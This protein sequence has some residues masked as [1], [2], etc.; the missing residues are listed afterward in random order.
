MAML[1]VLSGDL[2]GRSYAVEEREFVIGRAPSC[3]LVI[4]KRYI[5]REHA[6]IQRQGREFVIGGLSRKNPILVGERPIRE[7]RLADGDVFEVCGIQFRFRLDRQPAASPRHTGARMSG[8]RSGRDA[9]AAD[10]SWVDDRGGGG[11]ADESW[12]DDRRGGGGADESWVDDRRGG[13]ADGW[14][15]ASDVGRP[16]SD[17]G[18]ARGGGRR[19]VSD[20]GPAR[21]GGGRFVSDEGPVGLSGEGDVDDSWQDAG[22]FDDEPAPAPAPAAGTRSSAARPGQ[23][24][25]D[26]EEDSGDR[27]SAS[28][29]EKTGAI[30]VKAS[31]GMSGSDVNE[32]TAELGVKAADP[33]DPDY[34]PFAEVDAAGPK[35]QKTVDPKREKLLR[36]I[37]VL[38][39]FL[40][41]VAGGIV[42]K[43]TRP[44][45]WRE[46]IHPEP[47]KLGIGQTRKFAV[48]WAAE[49]P[50]A[51][52]ARVSVIGKPHQWQARDPN[53]AYV[54][55]AVPDTKQRSI[56]LIE[57]VDVGETSFVLT[58][59]ERRER[60]SYEVL[61][62]GTDPHEELRLQR[63][64]EL[65]ALP[66]YELQ[67]RAE[68]HLASGD[69]F[70]ADRDIDGKESSIRMAVLEYAAA[71]DAA[72]VARD[73]LALEATV[74]QE[75]TN[76]VLKCEEKEQEAREAYE[77]FVAQR[78]ALYQEAVRKG[79]PRLEQIDRLKRV[80]RAINHACD[81]RYL[82]FELL[83]ELHFE[84]SYSGDGTEQCEARFH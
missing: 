8:S 53:T 6:R 62:E 77:Q 38:A 58:F 22:D 73:Q 5:S 19:P 32:Q 3:N 24:V 76:L 41:A 82:R 81:V 12:V 79:R 25:F 71:S 47:I 49:N 28:A 84:E 10:E 18:P 52:R 59:P 45:P 26:V 56:F 33:D 80:L 34:D 72:T 15:P 68:S 63:R 64:K 46:A 69:K 51:G 2:A 7:H 37:T 42:W 23:V 30:D 13:A 16:P 35:A 65:E 83:L 75:L 60:V 66:P 61:V 1:D 39:L 36:A 40:T 57:G 50:P 11:G 74:P 31:G 21:G 14:G 43:V 9:A 54:E 70:L 55:W 44:K 20:V 48:N 4:P 78:I 27:H 29:N 17:I 67:S